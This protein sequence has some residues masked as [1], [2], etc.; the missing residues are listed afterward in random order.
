MSASHTDLSIVCRGVQGVL[1]CPQGAHSSQGLRFSARSALFLRTLP[2]TVR[3]TPISRCATR[4][5]LPWPWSHSS[6]PR[7]SPWIRRAPKTTCHGCTASGG[8]RARP[9]CARYSI[10]SSPKACDQRCKRFFV[11]SNAAKPVQHWSLLRATPSE[12]S[13]A[14]ALVP[15]QRCTAIRVGN[16]T[17]ETAR[18]PPPSRCWVRRSATPTSVP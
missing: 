10:R 17:T 15:P 9:R 2:I 12:P 5:C 8:Y 6:P 18:L 3:A 13:M 16:T 14:R 1:L 11:S 7:C 4:S